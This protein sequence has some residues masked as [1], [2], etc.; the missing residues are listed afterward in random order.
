VSDSGKFCAIHTLNAKKRLFLASSVGFFT[1]L[2]FVS[3]VF[4]SRVDTGTVSV[5]GVLCDLV[6]CMILG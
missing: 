5:D 6:H 3:V 4:A 1:D 2:V